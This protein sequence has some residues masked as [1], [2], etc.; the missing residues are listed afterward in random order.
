MRE[1]AYCGRAFSVRGRTAQK[2]CSFECYRASKANP[3]EENEPE[4]QT[5]APKPVRI[6]WKSGLSPEISKDN[7]FVKAVS[8]GKITPSPAFYCAAK[9]YEDLNIEE[10]LT[11]FEINP[12]GFSRAEKA[13]IRKNLESQVESGF[14][15]DEMQQEANECALRILYNRM[16]VLEAM[17]SS[18][19]DILRVR[20]EK[21]PRHEKKSIC[22]AL[23]SLPR[24]QTGRF[25][26]NYIL[27]RIGISRT[28]YYRYV[29][30]ERYGMSI[31]ERD[32]LD[33]EAVRYVFEYKGYA[34]GVRQV[35]M[36]LPIL[37]GRK[38]GIDRVRRIMR[39]YGMVCD[40]RR[41]NP[42]R[43]GAAKKL[44]E[45]RKPNL[46][47]RMFRLH[48]PNEVR[49]TDVTTLEYG[50]GKKAYG[51][52]LMDPVT[53]RLIAF[54]VSGHND[55]ELAKET[56]RQADR[57]PCKDGGI[58]HSDQGSIYLADEFQA[59]VE[60]LG[61]RQSMSR[62]GNCWD[63]APQESFFGHFKDECGYAGCKDIEEL[64]QCITDY[65]FY[66]NNERGLWAHMHM[67]PIKYEAYLTGLTDEEF[68]E[69]QE[70]ETA[71]YEEMKASAREKAIERNRISDAGDMSGGSE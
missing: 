40:V 8:D 29:G 41:P 15:W 19:L 32:E 12:H 7:P 52:A 36:Q 44:K 53:G 39:K 62:R 17:I 66:Y 24:D 22:L 69:Y 14:K 45:H 28:P 9:V 11:L 68:A 21:M 30:V 25:S 58:F 18:Q 37:T 43:E 13:D 47:R 16:A 26:L 67:T 23:S 50:K 64:K 1:C 6:T 2:Y 57:Y 61:M 34:K 10:I 71:K 65:S 27:N 54:I 33:V 5:A 56:L 3:Q 60:R 31:H 42:N 46:L 48:R 63:N 70:R 51:S 4:G 59:E 35:Y 55:I 20:Y 38:I 49:I